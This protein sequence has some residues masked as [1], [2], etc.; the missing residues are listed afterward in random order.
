ME[1][2]EYIRS[3][4]DFPKKGIIFRD[5]TTLLKEPLAFKMAC[6][7]LTKPFENRGVTKV[8]GIESRGFIFS[9]VV[10]L[11]LSA[12]LVPVRKPGKL[13]WK[14]I[15]KTYSLEYGEDSLEIHID[16]INK[17][18]KVILID[19]LIATGGTAKAAL[20]LAEELGG[21]VIGA[22]FL[23][24][25]S[26]LKGREKLKDYEVHTIIKYDSESLC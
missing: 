4:P 22:G 21:E 14:T 8:I 3:I 12:G 7:L 6:E 19:D 26:F 13:P 20:E 17:G 18:D 15:R 24:E 11:N 5:I 9:S 25:L 2:K 23:I 16:S 10:A 1:L